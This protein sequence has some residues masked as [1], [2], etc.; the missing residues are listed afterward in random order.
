[1]HRTIPGGMV[2]VFTGTI[3][4]PEQRYL[5]CIKAEP[6]D[7]F[8]L[9]R[10]AA[11]LTLELLKDLF[12]TPKAK[13][14]KIGMFV[15]PLKDNSPVQHDEQGCFGF[16]ACVYDSLM[17]TSNRDAAAQYFYEGFLGC[18]FPEN[19]ARIGLA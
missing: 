6:H 17:T 12:L 9:R 1:M 5:G 8:T 13:L 15:E 16:S 4:H 14:Y 2:V 19:A 7:G 18:A 11:Q 10:N 3:G